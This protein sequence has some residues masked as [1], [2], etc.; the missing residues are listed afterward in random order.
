MPVDRGDAIMK[1]FNEKVYL[2][3]AG[4][5]LLVSL[6]GCSTQVLTVASEKKIPEML[7]KLGGQYVLDPGSKRY[8]YT[9]THNGTD[10]FEEIVT[11][12]KNSERVLTI[13]V[14]CMDN[15]TPT[16]TRL[17]GKPVMLGILC[18]RALLGFVAYR[19]PVDSSGDILEGHWPGYIEP[20]ATLE[21]LRA[22][23]KA[24]Q[25]ALE[26]KNYLFM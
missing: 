19:F 21:E 25:Q 14:S 3:L 2:V 7:T 4:L 8:H 24:W 11:S 5:T 12:S 17:N 1:A 9:A 10:K 20:D 26:E 23:K 15:E 6:S 13:L 18:N 22:A 16:Q